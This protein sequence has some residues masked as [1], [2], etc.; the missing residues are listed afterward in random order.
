ME[1]IKMEEKKEA[2]K[3]SK[4]KKPVA[5]IVTIVILVLIILGMGV[6]IAYDKG[7]ILTTKN[8]TKEGKKVNKED[9]KKKNEPENNES[10][11]DDVNNNSNKVDNAVVRE[12]DLNKCIN[13]TQSNLTLAFYDNADGLSAKLSQDKKSV[14]LRINWEYF[15][16]AL[17]GA[18]NGTTGPNS[19]TISNFSQEIADIYIGGFGQSITGVTLLFL[20][21]DGTVEYMPIVKAVQQG[22]ENLKS[23]G[24]I[25][26]VN[27]IIKFLTADVTSG[28][29]TL[30]VKPDGSFY[31]LGIIL[32]STG[33]Y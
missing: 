33:N 21:K 32:N 26:D 23:Y 13:C 8:E 3:E 18:P 20:M 10:K 28:V 6:F 9:D 29:T 27:D 1:E 14:T 25:N 11:E 2:K 24:K 4:Q 30:A 17:G 16:K 5:F 15:S 7:L 22:N 31:D 19:Y 12:I